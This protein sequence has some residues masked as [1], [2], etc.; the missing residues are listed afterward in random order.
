MQA[1]K[2]HA[3]RVW[4]ATK[5]ALCNKKTHAGAMRAHADEKMTHAD[6]NLV[7]LVS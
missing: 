5:Y 6:V 3:F 7:T 2:E 1:R 4:M